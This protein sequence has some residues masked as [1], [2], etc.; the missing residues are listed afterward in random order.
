MGKNKKHKARPTDSS[1]FLT[2]Q[3]LEQRVNADLTQQNFRRAKEWLKEI[4]RRDKGQS[5]PRMISCYENLARQ[6][7]TRG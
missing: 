5:L 1:S 6:M 2:T 4:C 3:D 7:L